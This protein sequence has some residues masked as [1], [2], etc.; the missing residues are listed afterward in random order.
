[1]HLRIRQSGRAFTDSQSLRARVSLAIFHFSFPPFEHWDWD[2]CMR[3]QGMYWES[4]RATWEEKNS[5]DDS[6]DPPGHSGLKSLAATLST[7]Q[8]PSQ[9][10]ASCVKMWPICLWNIRCVTVKN[11]SLNL[12]ALKQLY[13]PHSLLIYLLPGNSPSY[14]LIIKIL[15]SNLE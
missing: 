1:M 9:W 12:N 15:K 13:E 4:R 14:L 5:P 7:L 2:K 3:S 10:A 11:R 8:C 6:F